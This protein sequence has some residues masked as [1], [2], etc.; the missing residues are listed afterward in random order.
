MKTSQTKDVPPTRPSMVTERAK[1]DTTISSIDTD[2]Y[3]V[4]K[5]TKS[6]L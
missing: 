5:R 3:G 6:D 1:F 4:G 2:A